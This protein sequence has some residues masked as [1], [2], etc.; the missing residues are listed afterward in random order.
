MI[1]TVRVSHLSSFP[2]NSGGTKYWIYVQGT[3]QPL[4]T[5]NDWIASL[6]QRARETNRPLVVGLRET[7]WGPEIVTAEMAPQAQT[8]VA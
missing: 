8:E 4:S 7:K 1:R 5:F 6:A 3:T 2:T